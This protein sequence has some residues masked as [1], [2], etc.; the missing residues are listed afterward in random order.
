MEPFSLFRLP[1]PF[2][3]KANRYVVSAYK[4]GFSVRLI[5]KVLTEL[6]YA[7]DPSLIE[8]ILAQANIF[9]NGYNCSETSQTWRRYLTHI[10][11]TYKP[12]TDADFETMAHEHH[13]IYNISLETAK[14]FFTEYKLFQAELIPHHQG[15]RATLVQ[16]LR[17]SD[18]L[19]RAFHVFGSNCEYIENNLRR[20]HYEVTEEII[21]GTYRTRIA[22]NMGLYN[23]T[24]MLRPRE[25]EPDDDTVMF[26]ESARALRM[27]VGK[28]EVDTRIFTGWDTMG[29]DIMMRTLSEFWSGGGAV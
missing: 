20:E 29:Y 22:Q 23:A 14:N 10:I 24:P 2:G 15:P 16:F 9:P 26:W 5:N 12:T 7:S 27:D 17:S 3:Y 18:W 1:E 11:E 6:D 25:G 28:L 8:A 4:F 13:T 19:P 21:L